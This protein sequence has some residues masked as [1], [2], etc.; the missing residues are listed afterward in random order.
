MAG[1]KIFP[2]NGLPP[3]GTDQVPPVPGFPVITSNKSFVLFEHIV[4]FVS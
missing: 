2:F 1:S 3:A 4:T